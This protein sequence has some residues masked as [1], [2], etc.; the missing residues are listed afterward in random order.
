[1]K[2]FIR[3]SGKRINKCLFTSK[4][5]CF[6]HLAQDWLFQHNQRRLRGPWVQWLRE[7]VGGAAPA[8][9]FWGSPASL[10]EHWR[11]NSG[12]VR[13]LRRFYKNKD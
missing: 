9:C 4:I 13:S 10:A 11:G 1:M 3:P 2:L 5:S 12:L 6:F 7:G 8:L